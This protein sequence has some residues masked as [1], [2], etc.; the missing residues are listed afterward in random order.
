MKQQTL[1]EVEPDAEQ[2][3]TCRETF[4]SCRAMKVHHSKVHDE[5]IAGEEFTCDQCGVVS[6]RDASHIHDDMN[7][8]CSAACRG[9]YR[10]ENYTGPKAPRWNGGKKTLVC[11]QCSDTYQKS[12]SAAGNS[13][14]CSRSCRSDW[15]SENRSGSDSSMWKPRITIQCDSC[16]SDI[17]VLE[18][19]AGRRRFCGRSCYEQWVSEE[20][21]G[22]SHHR[23]SKVE[24]KCENCGDGFLAK[25][26]HTDTRRFCSRGCY[27]SAR[28][29]EYSHE[30]HPRWKGGRDLFTAVRTLISDEW[31]SDTSERIR[32]RD[33][34]ECQLCGEQCVGHAH[35]TVPVS[36]GGCNADEL[37]ITLCENCHPTAEAYTRNIP[38]VEPVLVE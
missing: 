20:R 3:P 16:D 25:P 18:S 9:A 8:F 30:N 36:A 15:I 5:S 11:K 1:T 4:D 22:E 27:A 13:N 28:S 6:R 21:T 2:C 37:L 31:W 26:S 35:H 29:D 12:P 32:E 10:S 7:N 23:W 14:F 19:E 24:I 34:H 33:K 17:E 38:E